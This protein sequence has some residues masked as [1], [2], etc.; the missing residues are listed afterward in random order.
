MYIGKKEHIKKV[1]HKNQSL[2]Q[3]LRSIIRNVN[4]YGACMN[5]RVLMTLYGIWQ[6]GGSYLNCGE[7]F[8]FKADKEDTTVD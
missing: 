6:S 5:T 7:R 8:F 3:H 4:P 2:S 1:R